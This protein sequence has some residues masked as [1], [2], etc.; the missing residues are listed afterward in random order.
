MGDD[1]PDLKRIERLLQENNQLLKQLIEVCSKENKAPIPNESEKNDKDFFDVK[2]N[3]YKKALKK[4]TNISGL[5]FSKIIFTYVQEEI[6]KGML[7][8]TRKSSRRLS[9]KLGQDLT[10]FFEEQLDDPDICIDYVDGLLVFLRGEEEAFATIRFITDLGYHRG[11]RFKDLIEDAIEKSK[12]HNVNRDA[13]FVVVGSLYNSIDKIHAEE[14][15]GQR[16]RVKKLLNDRELLTKFLDGYMAGI[17]SL[18]NPY[19]QIYFLA[20]EMHP[21]LVSNEFVYMSDTV[22]DEFNLLSRIND[23]PYLSSIDE[24]I[25]RIR[26]YV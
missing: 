26:S 6:D 23:Y 10:D 17:D 1:A 11:H 20:S 7:D 15:V 2:G 14:I 4:V 22:E 24:L 16:V 25:N 12:K 21:N 9:I 18:N 8:L 3:L 13:V 5:L 19:E